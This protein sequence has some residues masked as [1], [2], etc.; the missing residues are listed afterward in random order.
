MCCV[1]V[2]LNEKNPNVS[3]VLIRDEHESK[4]FQT[5]AF[6]SWG[7]LQAWRKC[8]V[9]LMCGNGLLKLFIVE[10]NNITWPIKL[11]FKRLDIF[12]SPGSLQPYLLCR[13]L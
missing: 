9:P 7:C 5:V 11:L 3:V 10:V 6:L 13:Y 8:P 4:V 12:L 2:I 1:V